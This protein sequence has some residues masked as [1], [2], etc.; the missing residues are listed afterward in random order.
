M[1][2]LQYDIAANNLRVVNEDLGLQETTRASAA[3]ALT[4]TLETLYS[5][6]RPEDAEFTADSAQDDAMFILNFEDAIRPILESLWRH[7]G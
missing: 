1:N 3:I 4:R 7:N 5:T 2:N 6:G